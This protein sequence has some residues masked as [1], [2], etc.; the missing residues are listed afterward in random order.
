LTLTLAPTTSITHGT[1]ENVTVNIA[2]TAQSGT[3]K[4]DVSLIA[5]FGDGT[6]QAFNE[7]TLAANGSFSGK[8]ES[9]PGGKSYQVIAH[10]SGDGT[11][12][13][14]DSAPVTVSVNPEN[15]QTFIV[16]PLYDIQTGKLI[17]GNASTVPYGSAYR[18]RMYVTNSSAV[19]TASGPPNPICEQVNQ[20]TCP[21][22]SISLTAN[23]ASVDGANGVYPLNNAGYT[24]DIN[25]TLVGGTYPLLAQYGGDASYNAN[26]SAVDSLSVTK[27]ITTTTFTGVDTT[28]FVGSEG[29]FSTNTTAI[30]LGAAPTGQVNLYVD[31]SLVVPT[32]FN[33]TGQSGS[34]TGQAS[35]QAGNSVTFPAGT[36]SGPHTVIATYVGDGNYAS[37]STTSATFTLVNETS[38]TLSVDNTSVVYGGNITLTAVV[39][40]SVKTPAI[41]KGGMVFA[42]QGG[43]RFPGTVTYN[44]LTD[45]NGNTELQA[46]LVMAPQ[47]SGGIIAYYGG[48]ANFGGASSNLVI[49]NVTVPDFSVS[50]AQ[51]GMTITA[52]QAAS[53]TTITVT[54]TTSLS[55][56]VQLQIAYPLQGI[57]CSVSPSQVQL[58]GGN[59]VTATLSCSVPAPSASPT[60]TWASPWWEWPK[61]GA[62]DR[63]WRAGLVLGGLAM[64]LWV[65]PVRLRM[66]RLAY[67]SLLL[68]IVSFAVGCGGGGGTGGG[69]GGTIRTSTTTALSV[70]STKVQSGAN[71][72]ATVKVTGQDTPSGQVT[73]GVVNLSYSVSTAT[74]ANGQAQYSYYLGSPG[75]YQMV[76]Q[77]GGDATNLPS[78]TNTPLAVVQTGV[79]GPIMVNATTGPLTRPVGVTL[80]VQ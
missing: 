77:Y 5:K 67:V 69:G 20:V 50:A 25:P 6:T 63:W 78:Q 31:G 55:S 68:C 32:S 80:T 49:V 62:N 30:S 7:F 59:S 15:S 60:T 24:R 57:A 27:A 3:A 56:P 54:P 52:G 48:D 72:M 13:P 10:Y 73:L 74:L 26:N 40:T 21:T 76:A 33:S 39:T 28:V 8:T 46:T 79:A 53:T 36:P 43:G 9:L 12:A 38:M 47:Y 71:L 35:L 34:S 75:G 51:S 2:V 22:G 58:S 66:R 4:G 61:F 41:S 64:L 44:V 45:H 17:S 18:I 70:T 19:A 16:V 11:N 42:D 65:L 29:G 1:A 23:G 14:S 37:S